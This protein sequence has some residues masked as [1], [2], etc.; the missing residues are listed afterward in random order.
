MSADDYSTL[1][2]VTYL[3]NKVVNKTQSFKFSIFFIL[4]EIADQQGYMN[5][6][7]FRNLT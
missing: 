6:I 5:P 4:S 7:M 3:Y 2:N 1:Y